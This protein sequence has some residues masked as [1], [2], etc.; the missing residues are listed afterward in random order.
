[1]RKIQLLAGLLA[2]SASVPAAAATI[3][4]F[5][6]GSGVLP[7][8]FT[9]L[10][11]YEGLSGGTPGASIGANAFVFNSSVT[12]QAVRPA[13]GSAGN[14]AAVQANG[15][16]S[17][18]FGPTTRFG[19][20]V[21]SLDTYNRLTL[22]FEGGGTQTFAGGQIINAV[23]F[24]SGDASSPLANGFVYF[25]V[26]SGPRLIGATFESGG[27]SFEFDNLATAPVPE[28]ATWAIMVGGFVAA[29][30]A[31]RRRKSVQVLA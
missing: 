17:V 15:S 13:F 22:N 9:V 20:I 30:A 6:S 4:T 29:G 3:V 11:D 27:N 5:N 14:Y 7:A 2:M 18:S 21:G 26:T 19:F 23:S 16:Y 28:P 31:L 1:M 12:N 8:G 25:D 10:Q 24:P